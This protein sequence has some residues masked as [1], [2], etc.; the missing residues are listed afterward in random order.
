MPLDHKKIDVIRSDQSLAILD[1]LG[2]GAFTVDL[3]HK[4]QGHQPARPGTDGLKGKRGS[5]KRLP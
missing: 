1:E 5:R 2:V 4:V 3:N